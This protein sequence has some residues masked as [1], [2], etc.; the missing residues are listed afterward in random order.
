[1]VPIGQCSAKYN[2]RILTMVSGSIMTTHSRRV[3]AMMK[4]PTRPQ[5]MQTMLRKRWPQASL[6]ESCAFFSAGSILGVSANGPDMLPQASL[7]A[8]V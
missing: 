8:E 3:N 7:V 2:C 6:S 5:M 4:R 1:M